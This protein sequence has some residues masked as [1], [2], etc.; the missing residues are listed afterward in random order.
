MLESGA[1][2]IL[3]AASE[4]RERGDEVD[5]PAVLQGRRCVSMAGPAALAVGQ[6]PHSCRI[7][8]VDVICFSCK[9]Y[10]TR[11]RVGLI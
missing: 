9:R 6:P 7:E 4:H 8:R 5:E 11:T 2:P 3:Q 10:E 1:T